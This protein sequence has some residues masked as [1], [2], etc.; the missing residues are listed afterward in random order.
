MVPEHWNRRVIVRVSAAF[1]VA[2]GILAGTTWLA[3][4]VRYRPVRWRLP[5]RSD[6][7]QTE[8]PGSP[9]SQT[10]TIG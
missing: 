1:G 5:F 10:F 4:P 9:G 8:L 2:G 7:D 3:H 6:L